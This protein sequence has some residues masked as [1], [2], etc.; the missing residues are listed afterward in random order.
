MI[1][2]SVTCSVNSFIIKVV[3]SYII[4]IITTVTYSYRVEDLEQSRLLFI[5]MFI[6]EI[7]DKI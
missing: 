4:I 5:S 3:L 2:S 1:N 7:L 6:S